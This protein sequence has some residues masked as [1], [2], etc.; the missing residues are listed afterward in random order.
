MV[1]AEFWAFALRIVDR[2]FGLARTIVLARVLSPDDFGLFGIALLALSALETFTQTGFQAALI[3]RKEDV[4]PYL[5]TA[6]TVQA[7]RGVALGFIFFGIAPYVVIFLGEP[8]AAPLLRA[9]GLSS[10]FSF[11]IYF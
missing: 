8:N 7:I 1:Q 11:Y 9:F 4:R 5:D 3:Q 10:Y 2:L 6:W